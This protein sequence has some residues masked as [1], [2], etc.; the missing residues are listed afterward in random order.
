M[1]LLGAAVAAF[2]ARPFKPFLAALRGDLEPIPEPPEKRSAA[3]VS[4]GASAFWDR[5]LGASAR[6]DGLAIGCATDFSTVA[7]PSDPAPSEGAACGRLSAE[8][9]TFELHPAIANQHTLKNEK[10][11]AAAKREVRTMLPP[12][13]RFQTTDPKSISDATVSQSWKAAELVSRIVSTPR[14]VGGYQ[15]LPLRPRALF[16]HGATA[17]RP[18]RRRNPCS[19]PHCKWLAVTG[20]EALFSGLPTVRLA[21]LPCGAHKYV[22]VPA[23]HT[24]A[25]GLYN[26]L[27]GPDK[28]GT[29]VLSELRTCP[30]TAAAALCGRKIAA[31]PKVLGSALIDSCERNLGTV[32]PKRP[33]SDMGIRFFC[34]NGHKLNVKAFQAGKRGIC[35][36]CGSSMD[37]PP[38]STRVSTREER[39][40][41]KKS[42]IR[43]ASAIGRTGRGADRGRGESPAHQR[44]IGRQ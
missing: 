30:R 38:T 10:T 43:R 9:S 13:K 11:A 17:P 3:G 27:I 31:P 26:R 22:S 28:T 6:S 18:A 25:R 16:R 8:C 21:H 33:V 37:I 14:G 24:P 7:C 19:S 44:A 35:P 40:R 5:L 32:Q 29:A 42:R 12:T 15:N 20:R 1:G 39:R 36:H 4:G 34:P 41:R 23:L 2:A